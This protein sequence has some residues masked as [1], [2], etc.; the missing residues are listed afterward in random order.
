VSCRAAVFVLGSAI[1]ALVFFQTDL[2]IGYFLLFKLLLAFNI[3]F[4]K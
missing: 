2:V 3:G 1:F 4:V